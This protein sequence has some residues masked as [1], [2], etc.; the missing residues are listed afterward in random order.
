MIAAGIWVFRKDR[1]IY[2]YGA[3]SS[4]ATDRKQMAPYLLQW[5]A[6]L[7]AKRAGIRCY[8]F[9]GVADPNN[10]EDSLWGVTRFKE[11][12]G[13]ELVHL[14][15]KYSVSFS[16]KMRWFFVF[17]RVKKWFKRLWRRRR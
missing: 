5:H 17:R 9:L 7:D 8:D 3:S 15:K 6:I 10:P 12:F 2:Y 16:K 14:P 13:G 11:R 1:A 4:D